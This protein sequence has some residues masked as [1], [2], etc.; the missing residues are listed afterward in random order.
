MRACNWITGSSVPVTWNDARKRRQI[1]HRRQILERAELQ[2]RPV[3][4]TARAICSS[5]WQ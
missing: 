1:A 3:S 5:A 4:R 2:Q